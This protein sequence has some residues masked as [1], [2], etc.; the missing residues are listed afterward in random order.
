MHELWF[1]KNI[2]AIISA[3][4]K[5]TQG[6]CVREVNVDI[7][8]LLAVDPSVLKFN[9]HVI[10]EKTLGEN[11]QLVINTI[12]GEAICELCHQQAKIN[13]YLDTCN[14]CNNFSLNIT[15]GEEFQ[16]KSMRI[17]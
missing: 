2:L 17:E 8:A 16:V 3:K 7:G 5:E 1:C 6:K 4:L 11:V 10:A 13:S 9:F 12:P 15:R 14:Y